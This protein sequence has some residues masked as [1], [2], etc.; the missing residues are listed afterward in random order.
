[1]SIH[2]NYPGWLTNKE[3]HEKLKIETLRS[4]RNTLPISYIIIDF[5]NYLK[6]SNKASE[7]DYYTFIK[8]FIITI[9]NYSR[10]LDIKYLNDPYRIEILLLDTSINAAKLFLNKIF[11]KLKDALK[12]YNSELS[13]QLV[14]YSRISIFPV[15]HILKL[16]KIETIPTLNENFEIILD[17]E[18]N[19]E[20]M[21]SEEL[22][23]GNIVKDGKSDWSYRVLKRNMDIILA[24]LGIIIFLPF[25]I[26]IGIS[27]KLTSKGPILFKQKRLGYLGKQFNFLKFRTMRIDGDENIHKEYITQL[28]EGKNVKINSGSKQKPIYKITNDHRVTKVGKILR[29]YSFDELP[30]FFNVLKG[31]MS[32]VG[33]R[34]PIEYEVELY[35][36]W[37]LRRILEIKPGITGIWQVSGRSETTFDEM[38][39]LDLQYAKRRS[40][41]LDLKIILKTFGAVF[42]TEG[43]Y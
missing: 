18:N 14:N 15:K 26:L 37:H 4:E 21:E 33:P 32:L 12:A 40:F 43:A 10:D 3:F 7:G 36:N 9:T 23:L 42:S 5:S 24:I 41:V 39:R 17:W 13:L 30:Q 16:D 20:T 2:K 34:P 31:D 35:K 6:S 11:N 38:V 27:I 22:V 29:K 25:M 8:Q 28:I 1:M 19:L